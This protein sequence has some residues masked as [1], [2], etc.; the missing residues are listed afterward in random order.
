M[1]FTYFSGPKFLVTEDLL[2]SRADILCITEPNPILLSAV[3]RSGG[4]GLVSSVL[5][6]DTVEAAHLVSV[7]KFSSFTRW[8]GVHRAVL[9]FI[10]KLK[11]KLKNKNPDKF[12]HLNVCDDLGKAAT[13][14]VLKTEQLIQFPDVISYFA[15]SDAA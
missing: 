10:N 3:P 4:E 9:H 11:F 15:K 13:T 2:A 8:V 14:W 6:V 12:A 5:H 1:K 7:E